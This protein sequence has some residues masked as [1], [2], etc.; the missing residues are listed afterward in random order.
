MKGE[1]RQAMSRRVGGL[2]LAGGRSRRFGAEKAMARLAG[3]PLLAWSLAALD[4]DC[5]AV[6][7]SAICGSGTANMASS[8]GHDVL[9]DDP[10]N[11]SGPLAGLVAGLGWAKDH[12]FDPLVTLPCDT[13]LV[14][15]PEVAALI[16]ALGE[17]RAAYAT[18]PAGPQPLCAVWRVDLAQALAARLAGGDHPSV[19]DFLAEIGAVPVGFDDPLVFQNA[20]T[21]DALARLERGA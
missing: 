14:G 18:T 13:P 7:V 3:R 2:V 9:S 16:A 12:G 20:N 6:A 11:A 10:A 4:E 5:A 1:G 19:R 17:A 21:P 15:P 8:L